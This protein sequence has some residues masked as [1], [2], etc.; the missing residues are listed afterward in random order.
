MTVLV[1]QVNRLRK[2]N[3]PVVGFGYASFR[4]TSATLSAYCAAARIPSIVF[5]PAN[6]ISIAQLVQPIANGAFVLSLNINFDSCM[7]LIR[8][9]G[10]CTQKFKWDR[11]FFVQTK[12]MTQRGIENLSSIQKAKNIY[13]DVHTLP[14][15][16][17]NSQQQQLHEQ[18][19][20]TFKIFSNF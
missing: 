7:Q 3:S 2:M 13:L 9:S 11:G 19:T 14:S 20:W 4:D 5:L 1:S 8:E 16:I 6:G 12:E 17:V 10:V 15:S 18:G